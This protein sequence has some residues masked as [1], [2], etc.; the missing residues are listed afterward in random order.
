[1]IEELNCP[2]KSALPPGRDVVKVPAHYVP[3]PPGDA[4]G[5]PA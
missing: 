3:S 5:E 2:F 1:M 4:S